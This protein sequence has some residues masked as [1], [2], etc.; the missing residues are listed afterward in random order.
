VVNCLGT[1]AL[2][3]CWTIASKNCSYSSLFLALHSHMLT[4]IDDGVSACVE[5]A[6]G[7]VSDMVNCSYKPL[8]ALSQR[9][10]LQPDRDTMSWLSCSLLRLHHVQRPIVTCRLGTITL[11][12]SFEDTSR[13]DHTSRGLHHFEKRHIYIHASM[14]VGKHIPRKHACCMCGRI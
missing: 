2:A 13:I 3:A 12:S 11:A 8:A 14:L 5:V 4:D 7:E 9:P 10:M 1:I 6:G